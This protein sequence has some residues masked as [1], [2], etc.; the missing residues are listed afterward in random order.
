MSKGYTA[1]IL[2]FALLML[3]GCGAR[4]APVTPEETAPASTA[5]VPPPPTP[6]PILSPPPD[7]IPRG[8][9]VVTPTPRASTKAPAAEGKHYP[10]RLPEN[11]G[12]EEPSAETAAR[13]VSYTVQ[14]GDC[15]WTIAEALYGSGTGWRSLWE[16]NRDALEDP[17]LVLIGQVLRLPEGAE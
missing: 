13:P 15:L 9:P 8:T 11:W 14:S 1:L 10:P 5:E 7:A 3:S 17:G 12:P 16:A 4:L 2:V 6:T